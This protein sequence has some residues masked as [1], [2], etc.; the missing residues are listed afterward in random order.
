MLDN[1]LYSVIEGDDT[2]EVVNNVPVGEVMI[3]DN[4]Q[5]LSRHGK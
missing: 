5:V 2:E 4:G 3:T 1:T